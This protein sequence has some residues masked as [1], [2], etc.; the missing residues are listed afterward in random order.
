MTILSKEAEEILKKYFIYDELIDLLDYDLDMYKLQDKL[1]QLKKDSYPPNYRFIF[2]LYDTEYYLDHRLPGFTVL[3]LQRL[4][5]SLD[6]PNYFCLILSQQDITDKLKYAQETQSNDTVPIANITNMLNWP[7]YHP[8]DDDKTLSNDLISKKFITLNRITRFH[9]R[10][11]VSL[12]LKRNLA[13]DGMVSYN[14]AE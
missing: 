2:L 12:L 3:N 14:N 4:L 8:L 11:L 10:V 9:R 7:I 13:D 6:I 1:N 5:S